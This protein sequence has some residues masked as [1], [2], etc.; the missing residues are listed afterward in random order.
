MQV[1]DLKENPDNPRTIS[2]ASFEIL[3]E[4][5]RD[6]PKMMPYRP[7]IVDADNIVLGG[8]MR[9]RAMRELG[10]EKIPAS[11]VKSATDLTPEEQA[12]FIIA[13]N[14]VAGSWEYELLS[15][16]W[17]LDDLVAWGVEVEI[18]TIDKIDIDKIIDEDE[19]KTFSTQILLMRNVIANNLVK[20]ENVL[21]SEAFL[22]A[23]KL[24]VEL[25]QGNEHYTD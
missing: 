13:D 12:R 16:K 7:L 17:E 8:N 24:I 5:I 23:E 14:V 19:T 21:L 20:A 9:L 10:L 4:S 6:F 11:W 22:M 3:K 1:A 25:I 2:A 15:Q 18:P